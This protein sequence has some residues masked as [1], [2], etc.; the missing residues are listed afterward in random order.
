MWHTHS[1]GYE[2]LFELSVDRFWIN[3]LQTDGI[4]L[5]ARSL[6]KNRCI[7]HFP[8]VDSSYVTYNCILC[9]LCVY[10]PSN[11]HAF[12]KAVLKHFNAI[13]MP[14]C[15]V[16]YFAQHFSTKAKPNKNNGNYLCFPDAKRIL[17]PCNIWRYFKATQRRRIS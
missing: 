9:V 17:L 3:Y 4:E 16:S 8:H 5:V 7:L 13:C 10:E 2:Y 6:K 12:K 11:K 14:K 1:R 15:I